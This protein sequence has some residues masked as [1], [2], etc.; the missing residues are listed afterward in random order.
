MPELVRARAKVR[1]KA[2]ARAVKEEKVR[3]RV[4]QV[5]HRP[6]DRL[7]REGVS[8]VMES[9]GCLSVPSRTR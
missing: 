8:S 7:R 6:R 1:A 5:E 4:R 9:I 3:E 2:R